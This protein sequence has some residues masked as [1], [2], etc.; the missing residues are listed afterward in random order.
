VKDFGVL[1]V[2]VRKSSPGG[3][4]RSARKVCAISSK[5]VYRNEASTEL[6][7]RVFALDRT[8]SGVLVTKKAMATDNDRLKSTHF[9]CLIGRRVVLLMRFVWFVSASR[10]T[11]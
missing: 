8:V 2:D 3:N 5:F 10:L 11:P 6:L 4:R 9:E 7:S 1:F